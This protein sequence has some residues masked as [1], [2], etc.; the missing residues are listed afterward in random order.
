MNKAIL[1]VATDNGVSVLKPGN[2]ATDYALSSRGLVNRKCGCIAKAGDGRLM[3]GTHD[4]FVQTSKDGTEW[5]PSMEGISRPHITALAR[6]PKHKHLVFAGASPP[7]VYMSADYGTTWQSLAPLEGLPSATRWSFPDPPYRSRVSSV[8]CH[9]EHNGV[10]FCSIENGEMAASKDG[11]KTWIARGKGLPTGV[12]QFVF[13]AGTSHRVYA[14]TGTGFYRSD[15]LGGVWTECNKG[16]PFTKVE[17]LAVAESNSEIVLLSV[18]SG[19]KGP[20]TL[21][22]SRDG[23]RSWTVANTGLPRMDSRRVTCLAFGTGGFYAG[24]DQGEIFLLNNM[25]GRWT[26]VMANLDPIRALTTLT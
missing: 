9:A 14:A 20:C 4:F 19:A 10:V 24:T 13:P 21:V 17:A 15:D 22:L 8:A 23:G 1:A 11:G 2:E 3:V 6:H 18:A 25:E 12:R 7:A 26:L 16:L 5:K